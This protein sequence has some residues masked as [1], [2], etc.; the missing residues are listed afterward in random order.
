MLNN[1]KSRKS[2]IESDK[3]NGFV[4]LLMLYV[5]TKRY[6]EL[7]CFFKIKEIIQNREQQRK[8]DKDQNNIDNL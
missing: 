1:N 4:Y 6:F 2:K 7:N 3:I 8:A 5:L